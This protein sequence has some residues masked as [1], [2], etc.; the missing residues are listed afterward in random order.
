MLGDFSAILNL[1]DYITGLNDDTLDYK[2]VTCLLNGTAQGLTLIQDI[3]SLLSFIKSDVYVL[4]SC[5]LLH[6]YRIY[7]STLDFGDVAIVLQLHPVGFVQFRPD[8]EVEVHDLV[9]FSDQCGGEPQ[10][11]VSLDNG[12][13]TTEHLGC[14]ENTEL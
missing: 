13:D 2:E 5:F 10:F 14:R 7:L 4:Q 3:I 9:V 11:T 8:E 6:D 12:Q 1:E